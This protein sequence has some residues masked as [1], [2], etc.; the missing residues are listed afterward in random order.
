MFKNNYYTNEFFKIK[1]NS[2][3]INKTKINQKKISLVICFNFN[4]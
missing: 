4:T 2:C 3:N 1:A